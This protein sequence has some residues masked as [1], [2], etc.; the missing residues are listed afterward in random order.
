M[1]SI[2]Q[3]ADEGSISVA[4]IR[5][6]PPVVHVH[7]SEASCG[8]Q[9]H[10]AG[11]VGLLN[12]GYRQH[13]GKQAPVDSRTGSPVTQGGQHNVGRSCVWLQQAVGITDKTAVCAQKQSG[14]INLVEH[15]SGSS[16]RAVVRP[17]GGGDSR[18]D[19]P[20]LDDHER[21][22]D[23]SRPDADKL[24]FG[25]LGVK[26]TARPFPRLASPGI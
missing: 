21:S 24:L 3:R 14:G 4:L 8:T 26:R 5:R 20:G 19:L 25:D 7:A 22:R 6:D 2:G 13:I 1:K 15:A 18:R 23:V 9:L 10:D 12:L 17:P 16:H 11:D